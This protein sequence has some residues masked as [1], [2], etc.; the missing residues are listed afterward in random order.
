MNVTVISRFIVIVKSLLKGD[1]HN[2][3]KVI[4]IIPRWQLLFKGECY[5]YSPKVRDT[6]R[7]RAREAA[8]SRL[9]QT[10]SMVII[11]L[12][13]DN[14][15]DYFDDY[16]DDHDDHFDDYDDHKKVLVQTHSMVKIILNDLDGF[17]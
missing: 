11:I 14:F 1:N 6:E 17:L 3:N 5:Y 2:G 13:D 9:V 12:N 8:A 4:I 16:F 10:H 15:Y 7:D